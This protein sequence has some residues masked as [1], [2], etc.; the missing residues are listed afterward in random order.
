MPRNDSE[1]LMM[2]ESVQLFNN[3]GQMTQ[4]SKTVEMKNG[5]LNLGALP[6]KNAWA[7]EIKSR[8]Y[9]NKNFQ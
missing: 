3:S 8:R 7:G 1:R 9:L 2:I 6:T 5:T 4:M